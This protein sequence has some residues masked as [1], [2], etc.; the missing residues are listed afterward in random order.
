[1][2]QETGHDDLAQKWQPEYDD[3]TAAFMKALDAQAAAHNG[4]IPPALDGQKGGYD[5]G[6][7]LACDY[8]LILPPHDPRVT[9]TL[10]ATQAKYKE[11]IMTYADGEFLHHYLTIKNTL[12]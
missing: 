4:Y 6:N 5:W 12:D 2:A 1:M 10:R 7:M 9:A 8:E 3:Y 11:G